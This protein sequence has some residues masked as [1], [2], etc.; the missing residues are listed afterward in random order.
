LPPAQVGGKCEPPP[1]TRRQASGPV[2]S[3]MATKTSSRKVRCTS[4]IQ[5]GRVPLDLLPSI[6]LTRRSACGGAAERR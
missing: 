5:R 1:R 4:R 6:P 3:N 2:F